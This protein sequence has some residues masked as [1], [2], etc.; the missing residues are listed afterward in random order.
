MKR[1]ILV[2]LLMAA[3]VNAGWFGPGKEEQELIQRLNEANQQL[4]GQRQAT[5]GW[6]IVAGITQMYIVR[7]D[8]LVRTT[9]NPANVFLA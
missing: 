9:S 2:L 3:H 7:S 4:D 8:T 1:F 6:E 5:G